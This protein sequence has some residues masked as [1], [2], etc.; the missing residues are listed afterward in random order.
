MKSVSIPALIAAMLLAGP[1]IGDTCPQ[2][3]DHTGALTALIEEARG[4]AT[5]MAGR[6]VGERMWA[7]WADAPNAQAQ[8]ILDRGMSR[9][10]SYDL[11]G[12]V[13]DFDLIG[14]VEDFDR[15]IA[16]CPDYAEGYNQRAFALYLRQDF[17]AAL[18]DLDRA[19]ERSPRHIA[20]L[21]G[22]ALALAALG[23]LE[24]ARAALRIALDL[25]PWL[26]ER[27]L[28]EDGALLAP[29]GE[30]I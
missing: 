26:P 17:A 6:Q 24:T 5:E 27:R 19:L 3:P 13:E 2:A 25:N 23:R 16:Y 4:A 30:D 18:A 11:I 15:L 10:R 20:A 12:A 8:A 9:R 7:L 21:A 29:P 14:A 1:V 28:L 22:R